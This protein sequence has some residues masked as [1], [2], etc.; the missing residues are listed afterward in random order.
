MFAQKEQRRTIQK[1]KDVSIK[2]YQ[3]EKFQ[4]I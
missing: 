4:E 1:T 3:K 2:Q